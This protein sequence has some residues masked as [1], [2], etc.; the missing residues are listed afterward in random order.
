VVRVA[1]NFLAPKGWVKGEIICEVNRVGEIS[2]VLDIQSWEN[3]ERPSEPTSL[4]SRDWL[5]SGIQSNHSSPWSEYVMPQPTK[6]T[7]LS[8]SIET[9]NGGRLTSNHIPYYGWDPIGNT[10]SLHPDIITYIA[11]GQSKSDAKYWIIPCINLVLSPSFGVTQAHRYTNLREHPLRIFPIP[12]GTDD[13]LAS[14]ASIQDKGWIQHNLVA[15]SYIVGFFYNGAPAFIERLPDNN[16]ITQELDDGVARLGV[17]SVMIGEYSSEEAEMRP[18]DLLPVLS[19]ATG[20]PVGG[21]WIEFRDEDAQ[22]VYRIHANLGRYTYG[23]GRPVVHDVIHRGGLGKLLTEAG[24]STILSNPLIRGAL[25]N[26]AQAISGEDVT[27]I[28]YYTFTVLDGIFKYYNIEPLIHPLKSFLTQAQISN[29]EQILT[30]A[31]KDIESL[32]TKIT[33][34]TSPTGKKQSEIIEKVAQKAR[35]QPLEKRSEFGDKLATLVGRMSLNDI[36]VLSSYFQ[37]IDTWIDKV[38]LY[39]NTTMHATHYDNI[40]DPQTRQDLEQILPHLIDILIRVLLKAV[41]Y[42]GNYA[43]YMESPNSSEEVDW[44]KQSTSARSLGYK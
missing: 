36:E 34:P 30:Q 38:N 2:V 18:V 40:F 9:P 1:S 27:T 21:S 6:N 25:R 15:M 37:N 29:I 22:L 14:D 32:K 44:V 7:I 10:V 28:C 11:G 31:K 16:Q 19:L 3:N 35:S 12:A 33:D 26:S 23:H 43:P 24:H 4:E 17:T 13:F 39:R 5:I 8:M 20:R 41:G 42:T